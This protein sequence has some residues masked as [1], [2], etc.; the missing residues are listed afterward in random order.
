M[1]AEKM[2]YHI[3]PDSQQVP[4]RATRTTTRCFLNPLRPPQRSD[5]TDVTPFQP[6]KYADSYTV[7]VTAVKISEKE[8]TLTAMNATMW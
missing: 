8:S 1:R 3:L 2:Q 5:K 7:L 4:P 6:D